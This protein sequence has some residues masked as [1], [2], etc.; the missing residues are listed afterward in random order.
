MKA[1]FGDHLILTVDQEGF[2]GFSQTVCIFHFLGHHT[3][4]HLNG[5]NP[6]GFSIAIQY[7]NSDKTGGDVVA[8]LIGGKVKKVN[9]PFLGR[10]GITEQLS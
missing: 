7:G 2:T 5:Q 10:K 9:L 4:R 3:Q 8:G 6:D 1:G